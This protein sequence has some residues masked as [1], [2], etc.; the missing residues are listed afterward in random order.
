MIRRVTMENRNKE[1]TRERIVESATEAFAEHGYHD[2][3]MDDIVRRSGFSK[4]AIYFHFPGK[5]ALFSS[6]VERLADALEESARAS[7]D[8]ERGAVARVDAA[9]QAMLSMIGRH[10][11]LARVVLV[12]GAGLGPAVDSHLAKLHER[13][14]RFIKGYLDTAAADGSLP[15]IDTEIVARAWLGAIKEIVTRWLR[16]GDAASLERAVP[17]LRALLLRSIGVEVDVS[18][19]TGKKY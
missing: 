12:S 15:P 13:F 19:N 9:L 16:A 10:R 17:E 2:T 7:I 1:L 14:A 6:L 18:G 8:K 5:E 4:G 3:S 11:G